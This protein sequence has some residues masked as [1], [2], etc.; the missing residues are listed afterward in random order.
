MKQITLKL[1]MTLMLILTPAGMIAAPAYANCGHGSTAKDQVLN[2]ISQTGTDCSNAGTS[3]TNVI[4]AVVNILSLV[5]GIAAVLMIISGGLKYITSG[6]D[7]GKVGNAKSTITYAV[8]GLVVA[9][10]A[11]FIVHFVLHQTSIAAH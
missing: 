11:Q 2:G 3:V 7:A 4:A 6:G 10:L 5:V 1:M 8:I 9:A